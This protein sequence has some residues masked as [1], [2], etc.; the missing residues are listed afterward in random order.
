MLNTVVFLTYLRRM[1]KATNISLI[2]FSTSLLVGVFFQPFPVN[3]VS[4]TSREHTTAVGS[5]TH[6]SVAIFRNLT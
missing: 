4:F 5:E 6:A 2:L 3:L 1:L